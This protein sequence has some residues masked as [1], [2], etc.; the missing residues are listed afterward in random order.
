MDNA[1]K[2]DLKFYRKCTWI[3]L[4]I[5]A[6][7]YC[8]GDNSSYYQFIKRKYRSHLN[9]LDNICWSRTPYVDHFFSPY[10]IMDKKP[11][12]SHP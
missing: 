9:H 5:S 10:A 1:I 6:V 8:C 4:T 11:L 12:L 3:L 7:S 2:P